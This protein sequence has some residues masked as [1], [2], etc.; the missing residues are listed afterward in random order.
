DGAREDGH[1]ALEINCA[2]AVDVTVLLDARERIDAPL[3]SLDADDVGVRGQEHGAFAAVALE[4]RDEGRLG[5]ITVDDFR[6][7]AERPEMRQQ[8]VGDQP[9]VP[10]WV[11]RIGP[12]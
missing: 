1:A 3:L 2:P 9:L 11:A 8:R 7:D 10:R 12:N 4:A 6:V 5:R